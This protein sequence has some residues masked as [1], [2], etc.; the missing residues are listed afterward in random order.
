MWQRLTFLLLFTSCVASAATSVGFVLMARKIF[1]LVVTKVTIPAPADLTVKQ[2]DGV[3]RWHALFC[4]KPLPN[5]CI[6]RM[7]RISEPPI[8]FAHAS[9]DQL[10]RVRQS[11]RGLYAQYGMT[12]VVWHEEDLYV[13]LSCCASSAR[14]G[15]GYLIGT[16]QD[17]AITYEHAEDNILRISCITW[18]HCRA[19]PSHPLGVPH[20][21]A[22]ATNAT[23]PG[24]WHTWLIH[25]PRFKVA[26]DPDELGV[27]TESLAPFRRAN[28]GIGFVGRAIVKN[29]LPVVRFG[30]M[31]PDF[32][33]CS[34]LRG[35]RE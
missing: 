17:V 25:P 16:H 4:D 21:Q 27:W 9:A 8:G 19:P 13:D 11:A 22:A 26:L 29:V 6:D 3:D 12:N 34:G 20:A 1:D 7:R 18:R 33:K 5:G 24:H 14:Y 30:P 35:S 31:Q 28:E 2:P 23:W 10:A 32:E 15:Y